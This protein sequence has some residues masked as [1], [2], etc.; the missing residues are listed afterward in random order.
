MPKPAKGPN[1]RE[2]IAEV[3]A[4]VVRRLPEVRQKVGVSGRP[5]FFAGDHLFA[6]IAG[7]GVALKLPAEVVQ[8]VVD[9]VDYLPFKMRNKPVLRE[10]IR[11]KHDEAAAYAKDAA[12]FNHAVKFVL[13]AGPGRGPGAPAGAA[14]ARRRP[15]K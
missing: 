4:R 3:V 6:F 13:A 12:L 10:W 8:R 11:I 5:Q 7:E 2:D 14:P 1:Y 9:G 15:A